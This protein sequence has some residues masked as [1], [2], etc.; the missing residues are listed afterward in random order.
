[1]D[2][3]TDRE[4][5]P[6]A[7]QFLRTLMEY[8][9]GSAFQPGETVG[10]TFLRALFR[11]PSAMDGAKLLRVD[12]EVRGYEGM[13][14]VDGDPTTFWHTPWEGS[15]AAYPHTLDVDL[16]REIE[17]TGYALQPRTDGITGGWI[18]KA[19]VSVSDDG[20]RWGPPLTTDSFARDRQEKRIIFRTP[21]RSRYVRLTALEG[22]A[23]QGFAS[24]AEFSV[25]GAGEE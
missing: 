3:S 17:I 6:V 1:M 16:G 23:G 5:R 18:A 11:N 7:R 10:L 21:V 9:S 22:F 14:A 8:V 4:A 12:S 20:L 15:I 19:S 24:L 2:L 13:N 25:I